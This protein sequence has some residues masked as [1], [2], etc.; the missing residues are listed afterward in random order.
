MR[1]REEERREHLGREQEV[2]GLGRL[3]KHEADTSLSMSSQRVVHVVTARRRKAEYTGRVS[4]R[5]RCGVEVDRYARACS[6]SRVVAFEI[7]LWNARTR[8]VRSKRRAE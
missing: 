1:G 7:W 8:T 4:E 2:L 3:E 6:G 5:A